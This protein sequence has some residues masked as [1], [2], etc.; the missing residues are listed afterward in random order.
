MKM[1]WYCILCNTALEYFILI[2]Y[3][4]I[5]DITHVRNV[6]RFVCMSAFGWNDFLIQK[7]KSSIY[8]T[9]SHMYLK[10]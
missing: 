10:V 5:P 8:R 2:L 4:K 9:F 7:A 3:I 6:K 1:K